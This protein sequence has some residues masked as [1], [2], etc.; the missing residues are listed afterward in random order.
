MNNKRRTR[1]LR[2]RRERVDPGKIRDGVYSDRRE[3]AGAARGRALA[4]ECKKGRIFAY[5]TRSLQY[6]TV[7]LR[8]GIRRKQVRNGFCRA[9][10][11]D[12]SAIGGGDRNR[13]NP[14]KKKTE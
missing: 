9:R 5:Q 2:G 11:A 14:A 12:G 10:L 7:E 13:R 8:D 3:P 1:L 6:L 4:A